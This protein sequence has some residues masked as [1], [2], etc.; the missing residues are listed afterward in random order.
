MAPARTT[1]HPHNAVTE[2]SEYPLKVQ[3]KAMEVAQSIQARSMVNTATWSSPLAAA[4]SA[5][6]T[7]AIL[8]KTS[9]SDVA[10]GVPVKS[11][12]VRDD[13]GKIIMQLP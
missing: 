6:S 10:A 11:R 7:M 3:K 5:V 4:P 1:T 13:N 2:R 9:A 8:L 12:E